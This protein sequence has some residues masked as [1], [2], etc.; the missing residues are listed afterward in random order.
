MNSSEKEFW[1][2]VEKLLQGLLDRFSNELDNES[3]N[4]VQHYLDHS[5]YEMAFEGLF[6]EL[7]KLGVLLDKTSLRTYVELG[8]SLGLKEDS[9]FDS[10]FW[11][12]FT[13][14]YS[15]VLGGNDLNDLG[16][17]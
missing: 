2:A 14:Y 13:G 1:L 16:A 12:K 8:E 4:A 15:N 17:D 10:D 5:E 3:V 7:M 11:T 9:V 6:I